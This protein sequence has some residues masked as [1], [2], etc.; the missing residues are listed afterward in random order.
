MS[1]LTLAEIGRILADSVGLETQIVCVSG[2][3][4]VPESGV[5]TSAISCC[6]ASAIYQMATGIIS[7]PLYAGHEENLPFCRCMGGPAWFGYSAFD[8]RLMSLLASGSEDL[9]GLAPKHLKKSRE[10]AR[11]TIESIGKITPLGRY[12][13]MR[14]CSD[15]QNGQ[16]V[17]CIICFAD[18]EQIRDL[19]AL[20]HFASNDAFDA[21]SI[22]WGPSCATMVTYPAGMAENAP[23]DNLFIGPTD[24]SA[25]EWLPKEQMIMGIPANIAGRMAE[26]AERSFII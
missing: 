11:D 15:L 24:P 10:I 2:S 18:G 6:L 4:R 1:E 17:R 20:A 22:P 7:G 5:R 21:I 16:N 23:S 3:D 12:V 26:C 13:V 14:C 25:R 8:P 9:K 19:C